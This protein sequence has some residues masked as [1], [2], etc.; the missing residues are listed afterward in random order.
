MDERG[1]EGRTRSA[2]GL[3][4]R[5]TS[6]GGVVVHGTTHFERTIEAVPLLPLGAGARVLDAGCG[7]GRD[8]A[9]I[10]ARHPDARVIG[11]DAN[12]SIHVA[13]EAVADLPNAHVARGTVLT[14]S[15]RDGTFSLV[16]SYGVLHHT[17]SSRS[18]FQSLAR[19]VAPGG[20]ML[21]YVYTDLREEPVL[22]AALAV[23]TAVRRV[24]TRLRPSTVL[25]LAR[26][27]SPL[28]F[29]LFGVPAMLLRRLPGGER[30]ASLLPFNFITTPRQAVGDLYDRFSAPIE[31]RHSRSEILGWFQDAGFQDVTIGAMT[32][33]RGWVGIG[34]R[35]PADR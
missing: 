16:Y 2:F 14:P 35:A 6:T 30:A 1:V 29:A 27:G 17:G 13:A 12:D 10:A 23:V 25:R 34:S 19:L 24:T 21:I 28:V 33:A 18:A 31:Q 22:R 32:G 9:W 15:F 26:L 8:L 4:W 7:P 5:E 11:L 3:L 20:Q